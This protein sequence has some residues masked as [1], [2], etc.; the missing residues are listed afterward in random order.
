MLQPVSHMVDQ[1][2]PLGTP[3]LG[4]VCSQNADCSIK[5]QQGMEDV[6]V[7]LKL[8]ISLLHHVHDVQHGL[9]VAVIWAASVV[10]P[11]HCTPVST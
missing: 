7:A 4:T 8:L 2:D 11:L 1:D 3:V 6:T 5:G 10:Q 9:P